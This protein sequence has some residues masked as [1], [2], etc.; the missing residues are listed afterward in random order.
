MY[1][2]AVK[3]DQ[4]DGR[5]GTLVEREQS[6]TRTRTFAIQSAQAGASPFKSCLLDRHGSICWRRHVNSALLDYVGLRPENLATLPH[7]SVSSAM[8]RPKSAGDPI[9]GV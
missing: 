5:C 7:F 1:D 3:V 4:I 2:R 8:N 6:I 9:I